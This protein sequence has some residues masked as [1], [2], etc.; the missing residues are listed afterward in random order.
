MGADETLRVD[1]VVMQGFAASLGGAAEHLA[2]QLAW[3]DAEVGEMLGGWRGVSGGAYG[4]AWELWHRGA[5][6]VG[7]GLS[8]LAGLIAEAG[9]GYQRN[10][11]AS[12]RALGGVGDG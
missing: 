6:E 7:V 1:P 4:A 10:E 12:A 8:M 9:A 5:G 11:T 3:L 2:A